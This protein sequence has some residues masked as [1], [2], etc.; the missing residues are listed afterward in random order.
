M[1]ADYSAVEVDGKVRPKVGIVGEILAKFLP[2]ANNHVQRQLEAEGAE[3]VVPDLTDF[4]IYSFKN[5]RI[6]E[7]RYG[8]S[9]MGGFLAD[10]MIDY[11]E[12]YRRIIREEL[13][14]SRYDGP[15]K[16]E[17]LMKYA[18]EF[19]DLGNQYGEGWLLT[20]EM[21]ELIRAGAGN[22]VCV[23][24]FGCLPNHITGK[25]VIKAVREAYPTANIIPIDYD[26]SAS[27]VNQTNRIKLMMNQANKNK[28][29]NEEIAEAHRLAR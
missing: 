11:V 8:T 1:V 23:Q 26:A 6:K 22:I 14:K 25:G 4:M 13:K 10:R 12:S 18:E 20:A 16:V 21:V 17:T 24:P 29:K 19:V 9:K 5:A 7:K 3:V 27:A 2:E 28:Y 15:E